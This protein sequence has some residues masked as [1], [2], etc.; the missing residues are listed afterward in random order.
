[1]TVHRDKF[2]MHMTVHFDKFDVH[3]TVHHD[4]FDVHVTVH[5]DKFNVHVTVHVDKFDVHVTV[6]HDKFPII[7][8]TRRTI[9]QIYFGKKLYMFRTVS[10]SISRSFS[11]YTQHWYMSYNYAHSLRAGS[12][13]IS[14]PS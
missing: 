8:P 3:V 9:S 5:F 13:W 7:K 10:L 6:H 11:R 14:V 12:G 2:Y 1:M 4:K